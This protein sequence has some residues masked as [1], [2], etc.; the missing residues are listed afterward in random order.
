MSFTV[1]LTESMMK[2][3]ERTRLYF[4]QNMKYNKQKEFNIYVFTNCI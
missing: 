2:V 4:F 1:I 3:T